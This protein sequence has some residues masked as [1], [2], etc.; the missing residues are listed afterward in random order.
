METIHV[1]L[2]ERSYPIYIQPSAL[3][4]LSILVQRHQL[5]RQAALITDE[6]VERL[7][8][9][10][11]LISLR[12]TGMR[13]TLISVPAGEGQKSLATM[14][15]IFEQLIDAGL[16]RTSTVI[17]L[18][19]GVIGDLAG[20][21]AATYLRGIN[22]VQVPTTL[23]AQVDSS[24]GG[25][26]GVNHRLGKNLIGAFYQPKFV[27]IDPL[28]LQTLPE[29]EFWSGFSEV[30]KYGLIRDAEFFS[31]LEE[32]TLDRSLLQ[33]TE[34]LSNV[35]E[36]CC[37]IKAAITARD[38]K[39][40][41]LRRILN[42]GH[43][44]GHALEAVSQFELRHGEAV[45]WGMMAAAWLSHTKD[46]LEPNEMERIIRMLGKIPKPIIAD[47]DSQVILDYIYRDKKVKN[48][49]LHFVLLK[50]LGE[51]FICPHLSESD[52]RH[53]L[54]YLQDFSP[55]RR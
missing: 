54:R 26:T 19:G 1:D 44:I 46:Y 43:T 52:L 27:L 11:A 36:S 13:T 53:A 20:F 2:G 6:N 25:K 22:L 14:D 32:T 35:I 8:G 39:E 16:D 9:D 29:R 48:E 15:L 12:S 37:E 47:Y 45:A 34:M 38:E 4:Q 55:S 17:A 42:F 24:I 49:K 21:V 7:Y 28:L 40:T 23:M 31:T 41:D 33:D 30:M 5:G 10:Q 51:A 18:G 3:Q 50:Q